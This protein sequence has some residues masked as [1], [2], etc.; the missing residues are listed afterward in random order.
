MSKP[1]ENRGMPKALADMKPPLPMWGFYIRAS[2]PWHLASP[3]YLIL[4]NLSA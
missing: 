4:K 2:L 1:A 3:I